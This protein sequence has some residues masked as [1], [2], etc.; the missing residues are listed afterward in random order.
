[1]GRLAELLDRPILPSARLVLVLLAG[2]LAASFALPLWKI[3]LEAPQYP[4]GL[5]LAIYSYKLEP[6][7][8]GQHLQ[9]INTLNHYIGMRPLDRAAMKDLDWLPFAL[10]A[11]ILLVLRLAAIGTVRGLVDLTVMTIYL[12]VFSMGRFVYQLY[13]YGHELDPTAPV[14]V[15][16]FTP[17]IFGSKQIAN[18]N[19]SSYPQAGSFLVVAFVLGLVGLLVWHLRADRRQRAGRTVQV[20]VGGR[21]PVPASP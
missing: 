13:T 8:D 3:T 18:F 2:L 1:M 4:D 20:D 9:E 19:T 17:V 6:G 10:G 5:E 16:P 14:K 11:L 12:G 15:E 21:A 7:G